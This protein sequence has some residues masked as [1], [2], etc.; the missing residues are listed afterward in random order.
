MIHNACLQ[1]LLS[2]GVSQNKEGFNVTVFNRYNSFITI[3]LS[4]T[5][6]YHKLYI[7]T[8]LSV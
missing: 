8:H 5:L 2:S 6:Q 7:N 3:L 1:V 4:L